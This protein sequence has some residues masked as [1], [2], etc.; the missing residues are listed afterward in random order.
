MPA[1]ALRPQGRVQMADALQ[2][3]GRQGGRC[4]ATRAGRG[5]LGAVTGFER[6]GNS[7][8]VGWRGLGLGRE[9]LMQRGEDLQRLLPRIKL[10]AAHPGGPEA[11]LGGCPPRGAAQFAQQGLQFVAHEGEYKASLR[12]LESNFSAADTAAA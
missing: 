5:S 4:G 6:G 9:P 11:A 10:G 2:R 12:Q 3:G 1:A 7:Y 8:V